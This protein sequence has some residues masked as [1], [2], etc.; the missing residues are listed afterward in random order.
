MSIIGECPH[1]DCR[2]TE[3]RLLPENYEQ[4]IDRPLPLFSKETCDGC[5]R[6][7]W[8]YYSRIDP[9]V[10]TEEG[11]NEKFEVNEETK[12]I[13]ERKHEAT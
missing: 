12:S 8:V 1:D 5:K 4:P 6:T 13:K 3:W 9:K 10:Y 2:H 11:F 7:L